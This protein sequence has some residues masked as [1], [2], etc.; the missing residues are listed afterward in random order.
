MDTKT[1]QN[2]GHRALGWFRR[3]AAPGRDWYVMVGLFAVFLALSVAHGNRYLR[4][5]D[6]LY[7]VLIYAVSR[8]V[9]LFDATPVLRG[10]VAGQRGLGVTLETLSSTDPPPY[11][12]PLVPAV[13]TDDICAAIECDVRGGVQCRFRRSVRGGYRGFLGIG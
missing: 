12:N 4:T 6:V 3:P 8:I 2:R 13:T 7:A 11:A 10:A 9:G 1:H 5:D